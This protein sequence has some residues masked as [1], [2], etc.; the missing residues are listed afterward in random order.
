MTVEA[1]AAFDKAR[2]DETERLEASLA[3]AWVKDQ[4]PAAGLEGSSCEADVTED[5]LVEG[6]IEGVLGGATG[7]KAD[8]SKCTDQAHCCGDSRR[9]DGANIAPLENICVSKTALTYT[10]GLG[11]TYNH[12][13]KELAT[14]VAATAAAAIVAAYSLM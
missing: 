5:S 4:Q 11:Q 1:R 9:T 14:K 6:V 7:P 3:A 8:P 2:L 13:C 12:T 10:D